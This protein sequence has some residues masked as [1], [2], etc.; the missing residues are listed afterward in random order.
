M[1]KVQN[2]H[3]SVAKT[4]AK[5][6]KKKK[7]NDNNNNNNN[8]NNNKARSFM[9]AKRIYCPLCRRSYYKH[10]AQEHM[11]SMLHHRE[12][13]TVLGKNSFHECQACKSSSMGLHEYARHI[14][15]AQHKAKLQ[16]LMSKNV[17]PLPLLKIL[18]TEAMDRILERNKKLKKA[19]K[20]GMKKKRKKLK[21]LDGQ[22][23]AETL[24][25][26]AGKNTG[27][28]AKMKMLKQMQEPHQ[29]AP[30]QRESAL[31]NQC[32]SWGCLSRVPAGRTWH[33]S[34]VQ[35]Q[36]AQSAPQ[37]R[38]E[39]NFF[40]DDQ[41][42]QLRSESSETDSF[43][44]YSISQRNYYDSTPN[45]DFTCDYFPPSGATMRVQ[46]ERSSMGFS[47]PGQEGSHCAVQPASTNNSVN[48]ASV[49][50]IDVSAMLRQI[51]RA[52]GMREPCR[53]DR[54]A[55]KQ[56][57]EA[58]IR[59]ANQAGAGKK[60]PAGVSFRNHAKK[61]T[62]SA[63]ATSVQSS[64]VS[65]PAPASHP[66][67]FTSSAAPAKRK[68]ATVKV[69]QEITQ[70][71]ERS[72]VAAS[73]SNGQPRSSKEKESQGEAVTSLSKCSGRTAFS[74]PNLTIARKGPR[75]S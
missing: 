34:Y 72:S 62:T 67:V 55:R 16:S 20:K 41:G 45:T 15:T 40:V 49:P 36:F 4:P 57:S 24:Q 50:D 23:R 66:A 68:Q 71:G 6:K 53:A 25:G 8:N 18:S 29:K 27:K 12:L 2:S 31:R 30:R 42:S 65:Y 37:L 44:P 28:Q 56:N 26:A 38:Y 11:H 75:V 1:T 73:V 58:G 48:A 61:A 63:A 59:L 17:K 3:E 22:R 32:G 70:P 5:K 46:N 69:P 19:Q 39:D 51:R 60:Q 52:L 21:Q 35:D 13:E 74:E 54:E 47:Q 43:G 10:D 7:N 14:S 64:P 9:N 33:V